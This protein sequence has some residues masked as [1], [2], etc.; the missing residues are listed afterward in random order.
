M[1][2]IEM[3]DIIEAESAAGAEHAA[4]IIRS[5]ANATTETMLAT[6]WSDFLAKL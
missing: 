3:M 2:R 5:E 4:L 1:S 6:P